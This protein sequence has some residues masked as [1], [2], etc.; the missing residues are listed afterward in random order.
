MND[1]SKDE[2]ILTNEQNDLST[3]IE[4]NVSPY[5]SS[6][7]IK[8][9]YNGLKSKLDDSQKAADRIYR[10]VL[11]AA[12]ITSETQKAIKKEVRYVVDLSEETLNKIEAGEIKFEVTKAGKMTAQLKNGNQFGEKMPIKREAFRNG[13]NP[14]E[15]ANALQMQA[16]QIQLQEIADQISL[17]DQSVKEVLQGQ[18]NDRI[19]LYY[20]GLR[21]FLES[22]NIGEL[23]LKNAV[24]VQA[25][26][27]LT[28][29]SYQL[30]ETMKSDITY[31]INHEYEAGKGNRIALIDEKMMNINKCFEF[32]HQSALLRAAIY[33]QQNELIA[34]TTVLEDYSFFIETVIASNAEQLA[35]LDPKNKGTNNSIWNT[36]AK[37]RIDISNFAKHL[38]SPNKTLY[39]GLKEA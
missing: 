15:A 5:D 3:P 9:L 32:I 37:L 33:C 2:I 31:L 13:I 21:L 25:L 30:I 10:A 28:D 12:P 27:T 1:G 36:R 14:T 7:P 16:L 23:S 24:L 18:Q 39:I 29:A 6:F 34:M 4:S 8:Y 26:K 35:I 19:G 38:S 22:Q 20:S 17:I 11:K